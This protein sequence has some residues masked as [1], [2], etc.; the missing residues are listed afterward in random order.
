[1]GM[2]AVVVP[3]TVRTL[4]APMSLSDTAR[5]RRLEESATYRMAPSGAMA[6][7]EGCRSREREA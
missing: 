1:M 2:C 5:T 7:S 4:I 6:T 3:A